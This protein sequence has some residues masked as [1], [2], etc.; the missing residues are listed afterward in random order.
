VNRKKAKESDQAK[1]ELALKEERDRLKEEGG[2][3]KW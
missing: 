1:T 2:V 3:A